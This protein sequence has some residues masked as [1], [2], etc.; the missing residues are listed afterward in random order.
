MTYDR[1]DLSSSPPPGCPAHRTGATGAY[2]LYGEAFAANPGAVYR[3]LRGE[4]PAA[5]VELAPGIQAALVTSYTTA[6]RVM[7]DPSVFA[8]D[9]R[10]WRDLIE[11]RIPQ[12]S[13]VLPLMAYR[14]TCMF[15][16]GDEHRRLRAAVDDSLS[17]IDP[18]WLRRLIENT[19]DAL[20]DRFSRHGS[21]DLLAEYASPLVFRVISGMFGCPPPLA[22]RLLEALTEI[23]NVTDRAEQANIDAAACF[24]ELIAL[25][26]DRQGHDLTSFLIEHPTQLSDHEL[27]HQIAILYGAGTEPGS[28]LI[29]NSLRLLLV[30]DRFSG[31]LS[32]GTLQI[33]DALDEVLWKDPPMANFSVHYPVHDVLLDGVWLRAGDPVVISLAASNTDPALPTEGRAGN[34]AHLSWGAG[35]HSCPA[36]HEARLIAETAI[37]RLLDRLPDIRLAVPAEELTWRPG[38]FHRSLQALPVVF[39]PETVARNRNSTLFTEFRDR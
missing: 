36:Q 6:L 34:R 9:P 2:P 33:G 38:P 8:K 13:P 7:R 26:R 11:G 3:R 10:R 19:A 14:P 39:P 20:I 4:G 29:A 37:E 24:G 32:G 15:S 30:D 23:F 5:S 1:A 27:V 31:D 18:A 16:D 28:N 17:R 25:K 12:D 22:A 35:L 21:A